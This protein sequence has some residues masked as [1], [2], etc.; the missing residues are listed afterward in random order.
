MGWRRDAKR[1]DTILHYEGT[2]DT[3][4]K[5]LRVTATAIVD[6]LSS[7]AELVMGKTKKRPAAIIKN[8]DYKQNTGN[9]RSIIRSDEEDL[10]K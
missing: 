3:F 2:P 7:A 1:H 4:G 10:F 8:F 6:E 5:I 9:I